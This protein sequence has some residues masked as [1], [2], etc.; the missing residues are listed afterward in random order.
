MS[1]SSPWHSVHINM[2]TSFF[3][4]LRPS[5]I[6]AVAHSCEKWYLNKEWRQLCSAAQN[7]EMDEERRNSD[8]QSTF[9][10]NSSLTIVTLFLS[11][12]P[13]SMRGSPQLTFISRS[14][15]GRASIVGAITIVI[16]DFFR[17]R[18]HQ[19]RRRKRATN[20]PAF[21][22]T[23]CGLGIQSPLQF[24]APS[25]IGHTVMAEEAV[26]KPRFQSLQQIKALCGRPLFWDMVFHALVRWPWELPQKRFSVHD[27]PNGLAR[28]CQSRSIG[29]GDCVAVS[30][31]IEHILRQSIYGRQQSRVR[32]EYWRRI[33]PL[34]D[35]EVQPS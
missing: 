6:L 3:E 31:V 16:H 32:R 12:C 30:N 29:Q 17:P 27:G 25:V 35:S 21:F 4:M 34:I 22:V 13:P 5:K 2:R 10:S 28:Q 8:E 26:R 14:E 33:P 20:R 19:G 11:R 24:P 7:F 9:S 1:R 23:G 18:E 15:V